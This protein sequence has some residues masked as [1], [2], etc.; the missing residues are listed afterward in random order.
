ML[1]V[2][3]QMANSSLPALPPCGDR[4]FSQCMMVLMASLPK[5]ASG[6]SDGALLIA[7]YKRMLGHYPAPA[8][9]YLSAQALIRCKWFPTIAEC[10]E[11]IAEWKRRDDRP[12]AAAKVR[13]E[14]QARF[15]ATL[16]ALKRR[17]LSQAEIDALPDRTKRIGADKGWLW[18]WPD[19]RYTIRKGIDGLTEAEIAAERAAVA[20]MMA[21]WDASRIERE[22]A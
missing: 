1:A 11:I 19:G 10:S 6:D 4:H 12:L 16:D 18:A 2:L 21:S 3:D 5:R 14:L 9:D 13:R 7:A 22:A 17:A 15:D 8:I 20:Q